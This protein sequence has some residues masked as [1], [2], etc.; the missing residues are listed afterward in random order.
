M[1]KPSIFLGNISRGNVRVELLGS[2]YAASD[3]KRIDKAYFHVHGPYLDD[4]RNVVVKEF[5]KSP[6]DKLL[7]VDSDMGFSVEALD[8]LVAT[9]L[10]L[11]G[12]LYF[13]PYPD[14]PI[15]PV[16]YGWGVPTDG[17]PEPG[18][19]QFNDRESIEKLDP[20][21]PGVFEVGAV[22]T[23]FMMID[24]EVLEKMEAIFDPPTQWFF[25]PVINERDHLGE[26]LG[27]CLRSRSIGYPPHVCT[28]AK[29]D[30]YKEMRI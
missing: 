22:G 3:A 21:Q 18:F 16:V 9:D 5:L 17:D 11:V 25:E 19:L 28:T 30:H 4:A 14:A 23:G 7:F 1:P 12:G 27:F 26:D 2:L 13:N 8:A 10:P 15:K 6:C 29:V 20:V 24:R